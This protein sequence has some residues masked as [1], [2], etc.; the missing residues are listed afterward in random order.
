MK[1]VTWLMAID[2]D[3]AEGFLQH[4]QL[5]RKFGTHRDPPHNSGLSQETAVVF[6]SLIKNHNKLSNGAMDM[7]RLTQRI[8]R[9][10]VTTA[11]CVSPLIGQA[12]DG[13]DSGAIA[14]TPI[15][16]VDKI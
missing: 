3:L 12:Q 16:L 8:Y 9:L 2:D 7:C 4:N 6:P 14:P 10:A 1:E 5:I 15:Y 13:Q 11:A